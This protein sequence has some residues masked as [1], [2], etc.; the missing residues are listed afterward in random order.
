MPRFAGQ[1]ME[2]RQSDQLRNLSIG[3]DVRQT[4][5]AAAQG[6]EDLAVINGLGQ[7]QPATVAGPAIELGKAGPVGMTPLMGGLKP[8]LGW[9]SLE[10]FVNKVLPQIKA[11]R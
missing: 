5:L 7:G 8:E 2:P 3:V 4:I 6:L 11:A 1:F 10:L 9:K